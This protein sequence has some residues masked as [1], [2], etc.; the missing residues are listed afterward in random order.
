MVFSSTYGPGYTFLCKKCDSLG[1]KI[2]N[3]KNKEEYLK[4]RKT[5]YQRNR[6]VILQEKKEYYLFNKDKKIEYGKQYYSKNKESIIKQKREYEKNKRS[7]DPIFRIKKNISRRIHHAMKRLDFKK[8]STT[9]LILGTDKLG[10]IDHF[11]KTQNI[12]ITNSQSL[13]DLEID[14]I[15]PLSQ[16]I[17]EKELI[18]LNHFSNL[19]F[20][21]KRQNR[22]KTDRKILEGEA[23]CGLLLGREWKEK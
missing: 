6:D 23:M 14:H 5:A 3:S 11:L 4:N 2:R 22:I 12:D 10:L 13:A 18:I 19:Q 15:C 8:T 1:N 9:W 17:N 21:S 16:A 7:S 20:L